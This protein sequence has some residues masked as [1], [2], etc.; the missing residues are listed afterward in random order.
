MGRQLFFL[1]YNKHIHTQV[2]SSSLHFCPFLKF[3]QT[4]WRDLVLAWKMGSIH[5][6]PLHQYAFSE[7]LMLLLSMHQNY[8]GYHLKRLSN[9]WQQKVKYNNRSTLTQKSF[10]LVLYKIRIFFVQRLKQFFIIQRSI[11]IDRLQRFHF[12]TDIALLTTVLNWILH[13][14]N[15]S[16]AICLKTSI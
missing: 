12:S 4:D 13:C 1:P 9:G 14:L 15:V 11:L 7:P 10:F 16:F 2:K 8:L 5:F 3:F 6:V